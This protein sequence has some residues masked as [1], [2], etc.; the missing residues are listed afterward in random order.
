MM[1]RLSLSVLCLLL[2]AACTGQETRVPLPLPDVP[3]TKLVSFNG[4]LQPQAIDTYTFTVL[5][6]G[7]V[8]ATLVGLGAPPSTEVR[9]ATPCMRLI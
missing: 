4:T 2:A 6:T 1:V 7:Y 5:Q 8:Q 3:P 9:L